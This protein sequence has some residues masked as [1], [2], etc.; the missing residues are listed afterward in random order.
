MMNNYAYYMS[1]QNVNLEHAEQLSRR[2]VDAE[3]DN[4]NS[5]DTY[6][7]ILHLLGRDA[8]A[9]PYLRKAVR[10]NPAS[11]TLKKHLAE[12]EGRQ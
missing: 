7:W 10:L 3:P 2:T 5:L 8:D 12:V 1:E 4:A 6:G 11:D 9:L